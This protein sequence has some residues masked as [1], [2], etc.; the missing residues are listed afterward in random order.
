M[1]T[2]EEKF[3]GTTRKVT[4]HLTQNEGLSFEKSA[5][6]KKAYRLAELDVPAV[7]LARCWVIQ[8]RGYGDAP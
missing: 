7:M 5:P 3:V 1:A 6:G 2:T 4:G 8:P